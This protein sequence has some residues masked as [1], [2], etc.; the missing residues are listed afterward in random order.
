MIMVIS[1]GRQPTKSLL[2]FVADL[3]KNIFIHKNL[4]KSSVHRDNYP[5]GG[6]LAS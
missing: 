5:S 6:A 1:P 2:C 3:D 4:L